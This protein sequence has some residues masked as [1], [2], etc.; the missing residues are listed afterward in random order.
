[1]DKITIALKDKRQI[2][3]NEQ[4]AKRRLSYLTIDIGQEFEEKR[5]D[6]LHSLIA[7]G[8]GSERAE[9][10]ILG[11]KNGLLGVVAAYISEEILGVAAYGRTLMH[12]NTWY[13]A[14]NVVNS[15]FRYQG[16]GNALNE[17]RLNHL[18]ANHGAEYVLVASKDKWNRMKKFGFEPLT[19]LDHDKD[20]HNLMIFKKGN[21][22]EKVDTS[23]EVS[24][25][26][27]E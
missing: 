5:L 22:R 17:I 26:E 4:M 25:F 7:E 11:L 2:P 14:F 20:N 1:M 24:P 27:T 12:R 3:N 16:I 21:A 15:K 23:I 8:L 9:E 13:L 18:L 10:A 6:S 19:M